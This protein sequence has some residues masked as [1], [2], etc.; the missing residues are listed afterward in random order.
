[1]SPFSQVPSLGGPISNL[2]TSS[3]STEADP[4]QVV[5]TYTQNWTVPDGVSAISMVCVGGGGGGSWCQGYSE[6]SGAGGGGGGL[7]WQNNVAVAAGQIMEI[8]VGSG[9][10]AGSS[11]PADGEDGGYSRVRNETTSTTLCQAN[12]GEGGE[13]SYEEE[14]GAG[15]TGG[16]GGALLG[17]GGGGKGGNGG[18]TYNNNG[19]GGGGGAGG[20]EGNGGAVSYTHLTLPTTPYV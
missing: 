11:Y 19:G 13:N 14:S 12:G 7:A 16:S 9:G 17:Y 2:T 3:P 4:G 1:M 18:Q 10:E 15:G 20:Y 6:Q 5:F 8:T